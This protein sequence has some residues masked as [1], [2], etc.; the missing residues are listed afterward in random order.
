[1]CRTCPACACDRELQRLVILE[2]LIDKVSATETEQTQGNIALES[3]AI[4]WDEVMRKALREVV[5]RIFD[6]ELKEFMEESDEHRARADRSR[7]R[8]KIKLRKNRRGELVA[9]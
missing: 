8:D 3:A 7:D 4:R 1:M 2:R 9:K 5:V 6:Q